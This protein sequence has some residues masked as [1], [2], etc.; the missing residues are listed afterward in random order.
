MGAH[1][2]APSA[3]LHTE[4]QDLLGLINSSPEVCL[5]TACCERFGPHL[6]FLFKI[7]S[8][9]DPLSLQVHPSAEEAVQGY[10][11]EEEAGIARNA[12]DRIYHDE[13]HKPE[14]LCALSSF[15]LLTGFLPAEEGLRLLSAFG[16]AHPDSPL[17]SAFLRLREEAGPRGLSEYM[18]ELLR[19][20][21]E[22]LRRAVSVA[23]EAAANKARSTWHPHATRARWVRRLAE[24]HPD[25]PGVIAALLMN[26]VELEAGGA[27]FVP[28]GQLHTYL[29]GE[30]LELMADSD[31]VIRGGLTPKYV[32]R[33]ELLSVVNF[34]PA[35][36]LLL[37]PRVQSRSP[38]LSV[39]EFPALASEFQLSLLS[40]GPGG[41]FVGRGPEILLL[42]SGEVRVRSTQGEVALRRGDQLFCDAASEYEI[43][44]RARVA[45][46]SVPGLPDARQR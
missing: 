33:E 32:N 9:Q 4:G 22:E 2:S 3:L 8:A 25:D 27:V 38:G 40:L 44:G 10:R 13:R 37:S 12:P 21:R 35:P 29:G 19:Q 5:G 7:L 36:P 6:P 31:N 14:L 15:T 28:A 11:R 1:P 26:L 24:R 30:G 43:T 39:Q 42:L 41:A 34:E 46:A 18:K 20:P 17:F 16:Q 23:V 45:R